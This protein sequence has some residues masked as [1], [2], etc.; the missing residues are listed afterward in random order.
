MFEGLKGWIRMLFLPR[1]KEE[2]DIR[3]I[4]STEMDTLLSICADTYKGTPMWLNAKD[5][6]KTIN[7]AKALCSETARLT[8]L[9]A[10]IK[11]DD[12]PRG[13]Y[14]QEEIDKVYYNIRK[15][16]EYGC[17][18]G[19]I[20]LKPNGDSIDIV[21][22]NNFTVTEEENG[23]ITA[24][25]FQ[26][27][28]RARDGKHFYTR[29]EYH[30]KENDVYIITNKTYY[31]ESKTSLGD[32]I[33]I[34][35]TP[36]SNLQEEVRIENV[37]GNLYAVLKMPQANNVDIDSPMGMPIIYDCL[38]ELKDLDIAYS[39]NAKEILDSKRTILLDSDRM[40]LNTAGSIKN[41]NWDRVRD[42]AGL[43]DM[44][45]AVDGGQTDH[46]YQEINPLIQT[47]VRLEGINA[48]LSQIGYKVG[49]S[50]GYFVFN[51][52]M[53]IQTATGVEASQQRNIQYVKDMRDML[54]SCLSELIS[55]IN[56]FADLYN[57]APLGEYEVNFDFGDITYNYEEDRQRWWNY[58][59][60][61]KVPA[62][63]Y[64]QKFEGMT[65]E[66]AKAMLVEATPETV[67]LFPKDE[68]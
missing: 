6:I 29:L 3:P 27:Q 13:Q 38:E 4:V 32:P 57:L 41:V 18:Y 56:T 34:G 61:Q 30:R 14:L 26:D 50:N 16:F 5:H 47:P 33:E 51:E 36:W 62:W 39:R 37:D 19:T 17:A 2:F 52:K 59:V 42:S 46:I 9:G 40:L 64:F 23:N 12:G 20:I 65:E 21:T 48:L 53:G 11:F 45:K 63:M 58:V 55:A 22:P 54:E 67:E 28:R 49:F 8:L 35:A 68:E 10:K 43:P 31:S 44:I 15:W 25:V 66:E 7:F 24:V 60:T 1:A